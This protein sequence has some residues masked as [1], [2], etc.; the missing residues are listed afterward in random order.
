MSNREKREPAEFLHIFMA[1]ARPSHGEKSACIRHVIKQDEATELQ[2][3]EAKLRV[4]G[5]NWRIH[6][7]VNARDT[8]KARRWLL[9][10]LIDNPDHAGF[11]DSDWRTALLQPECIYGKKLFMLDVDTKDPEALVEIGRLCSDAVHVFA[12]ET[13]K[14]HHYITQPFDTREVCKHPDVTLIRDGYYFVKEVRDES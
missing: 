3:L 1:L 5:G 12:V 9:K 7:T 2:V 8:E 13:P 10:C 4:L 11:I 14:G 6:R